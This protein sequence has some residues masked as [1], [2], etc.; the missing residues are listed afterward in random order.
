MDVDY[1]NARLDKMLLKYILNVKAALND[2][3]E[4]LDA[5]VLVSLF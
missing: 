3:E 5:S 4:G 2:C 1:R